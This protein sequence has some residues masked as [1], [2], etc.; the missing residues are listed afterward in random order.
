[1]KNG[2]I[3][4][5]IPHNATPDSAAAAPAHVAGKFGGL[6]H[7]T[8]LVSSEDYGHLYRMERADLT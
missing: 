1:M 7:T 5:A 6:A 8:E 4:F 2:Y 3:H